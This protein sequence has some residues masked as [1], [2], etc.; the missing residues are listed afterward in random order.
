METTGTTAHAAVQVKETEE[1][2]IL[3]RDVVGT[4]NVLREQNGFF[5]NSLC[6]DIDEMIR[7]FIQETMDGSG[8]DP[9]L[10]R[11]QTLLTVHEIIQS[12]SK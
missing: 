7:F 9:H 12:L 11:M 6:G 3:P 10:K 5:G 8:S 2:L 1:R 4:L